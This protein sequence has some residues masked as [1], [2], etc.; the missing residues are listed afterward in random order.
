MAS[1]I[2][3]PE[4]KI[5]RE[6]VVW[7]VGL[8][9]T[10]VFS[11]HHHW[12]REFIP[13]IWR[14]VLVSTVFCLFVSDLYQI[15]GFLLV[16]TLPPPIKLTVINI[17]EIVFEL[18]LRTHFYQILSA[19]NKLEFILSSIKLFLPKTTLWYL[20]LLSLL[21]K[22]RWKEFILSSLKLSY[23]DC[24]IKDREIQF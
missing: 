9:Y 4:A 13:G 24:T 23:R 16:P 6:A 2:L 11:A 14:V 22:N 12:S 17:T 15:G 3:S 21:K 8:T 20:R 1:E 19:F 18:A 5:D 10:Y 7:Y